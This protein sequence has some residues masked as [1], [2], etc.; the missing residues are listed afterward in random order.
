MFNIFLHNYGHV[1]IDISP[2]NF[3]YTILK[4][5]VH[6]VFQIQQEID[7]LTTCNVVSSHTACLFH[8]K[9][10]I[11]LKL[12]KWYNQGLSSRHIVSNNNTLT[13]YIFTTSVVYDEHNHVIKY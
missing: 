10:D 5:I 2:Q 9:L 1:S 13:R 8:S 12:S 11:Y 3:P 7:M 4:K 6:C